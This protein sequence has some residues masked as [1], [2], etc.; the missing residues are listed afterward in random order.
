MCN[1]C[2]PVQTNAVYFS[3][4]LRSARFENNCLN[5]SPIF[6]FGECDRINHDTIEST[7]SFSCSLHIT[8]TVKAICNIFSFFS[9]HIH[10]IIKY[11]NYLCVEFAAVVLLGRKREP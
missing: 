7:I 5:Y 11:V 10:N 2:R 1:A 3:T 9:L 6:P 4:V 8:E